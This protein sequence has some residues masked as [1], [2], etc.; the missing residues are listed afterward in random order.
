MP[1]AKNIRIVKNEEN[2]ETPEILAASLI[3]IANALSRL[4]GA[5][6]G[7]EP[8]AI[9]ALLAAMPGM[10]HIRKDDITLVI[11]NITKLKSYY[12]RKAPK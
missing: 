12:V 7:L 3:S 2:P 10:S 8:R 9:T 4:I 6:D 11:E 5:E 1:K